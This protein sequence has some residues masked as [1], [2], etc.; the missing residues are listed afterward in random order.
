MDPLCVS[1]LDYRGATELAYLAGLNE[2]GNAY[3]K[4]VPQLAEVNRTPLFNCTVAEFVSA[5]PSLTEQMR[6]V[7]KVCP[8]CAKTNAT[9][10]TNCNGCGQ[11]L[12]AC[13]EAFTENVCMAFIYGVSHGCRGPLSLSLR[14]QDSEFL[15]YDD[16]LARGNCH[17][18]GIPTYCHVPD[19][20]HLLRNPVKGRRLVQRLDEVCW[21][22]VRDQF[23]NDDAWRTTNF[24]EGAFASAE[25]FRAQIYAGM[26]SVP[27]Q[28]QVHLQYI[29]PPIQA[30]DYHAFLHGKRLVKN[31]WLPLEYILGS[32]QALEKS[33]GLP[34]AH[35]M[36]MEAIFD[37]IVKCGGPSYEKSFAEAIQRYNKTHLACSNWRL[38]NFDV[39]VL[40]RHPTLRPELIGA[41]GD[42]DVGDE[43]PLPEIRLLR[44]EDSSVNTSLSVVNLEKKDKAAIQSYGRPY[45]DTGKPTPCA[46]YAFARTPGQGS[47]QCADDWVAN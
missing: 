37:A 20:R 39:V 28:Y 40:Y 14:Y 47:F 41:L 30:P 3:Y 8:R 26:N 10:L 27:S 45:D 15:V 18:N 38:E 17:L 31:R 21:M 9:I 7:A 35:T 16:L 43:K 29:V 1:Q 36:S 12:S 19:W 2:K 13:E 34:E 42:R 11:D 6:N 44:S 4:R 33:G 24:R 23:W 5:N 22:S 32:L 25:D 46:Y